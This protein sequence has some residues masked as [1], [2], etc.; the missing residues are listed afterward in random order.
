MTYDS[1]F[2]RLRAVSRVAGREEKRESLPPSIMCVVICVSRAFCS[3][4]QEERETARSVNFCFSA[5]NAPA[6]TMAANEGVIKSIV[7]TFLPR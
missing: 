5:V 1:N 6:Y 3:M 7:L 4:D 2:C